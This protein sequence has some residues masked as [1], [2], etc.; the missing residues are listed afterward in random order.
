MDNA[1][2][3]ARGQACIN[4]EKAA[5]EATAHHLDQAFAETIHLIEQ[6]VLAGRK[7]IFSGIGKN[8][9]IGEKLRGTFNSTGVPSVN[10]DPV[11]ALHGDL[12]LCEEGDLAFLLSNSGESEELINLIPILRRLGVHT[13]ALT[14]VAASRLG[15][16]CDH[17]LTY[18][19]E[20]EACPLN[21]A[22]TASTTAALALGDALAMVYLE[23]RGLTREDFARYHPAGS[24]GKSLLLRAT[25]IMR[26][27]ECFAVAPSNV[28]VQA[29]LLEIT[30][31][32]CGII[33]LTHPETG[34]LE[35]V[36]TDGDFRRCML[37]DPGCLQHPV[38][39][40]MTRNP[41]AL[42]THV[43]AVDVLRF[44]ENETI[45]DLVII[46]ESRRPVGLID[47][48][49]LPRLRLV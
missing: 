47:G 15:Q 44:L 8:T 30:R 43:L 22:P 13:V 4:L 36:F 28:T 32:R 39:R 14:S 9:P 19:V 1:T 42:G 46:D 2:L 49:D 40:Y 11:Q 24:L 18:Q 7:L 23:V 12:G 34:H 33:A 41:K 48:Q 5:L 29:A 16:L 3:I 25:E 6:A 10:L 21:L 27:D 35:G 20:Q 31:A 26:R 17:T 45:N 38:E 37:R